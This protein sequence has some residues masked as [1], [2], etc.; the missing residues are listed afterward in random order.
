M[1]RRYYLDHVINAAIQTVSRFDDGEV[2][3]IS[4]ISQNGL[5]KIRHSVDLNT[6]DK[7]ETS[8]NPFLD[9]GH[10]DKSHKMRVQFKGSH[11]LKI[12][13]MLENQGEK[14]LRLQVPPVYKFHSHKGM[15]STS[16]IKLSSLSTPG[17]LH[18]FPIPPFKQRSKNHLR[19]PIHKIHRERHPM[20]SRHHPHP[21][22][23]PFLSFSFYPLFP[24]YLRPETR[25]RG[26]AG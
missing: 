2:K 4:A 25:I 21:L 6:P 8:M 20:P 15:P 1:E 9:N 10:V 14:I 12:T 26:M 13:T 19:R 16:N 17:R 5:L 22:R 23:P 18:R 7:I 24:P 3:S 11:N